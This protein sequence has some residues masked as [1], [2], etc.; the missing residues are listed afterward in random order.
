MI[1]VMLNDVRLVARYNGILAQKRQQL[2]RAVAQ[3]ATGMRTA[4]IGG[5]VPRR[6]RR[7]SEEAVLPSTAQVQQVTL[8]MHASAPVSELLTKLRKTLASGLSARATWTRPPR[9]GKNG[10][11]L[12]LGQIS[13]TNKQRRRR[14][15]ITA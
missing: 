14:A 12:V 1:E 5:G 13:P 3:H 11:D 9:K 6:K 15:V 10:S 4:A 8:L 7:N 2:Q